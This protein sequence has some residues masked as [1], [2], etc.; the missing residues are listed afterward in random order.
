MVAAYQAQ[1]F[2]TMLVAAESALRARP[3]YPGALFNLALAQ[4]LSGDATASL[5]TLNYLLELGI[6]FGV[7]DIGEFA[8]LSK[9]EGWQRFTERT[10]ELHEPI[11]DASVFA[12]LDAP[13]FVP[14]GIAFGTDGSLYLGSIRKGLLVRG[15]GTVLSDRDGHWSVFGMRFH[16]DGGLWFAS[17]AVPQLETVGEDAGQTGLFRYNVANGQVDKRAML[18]Q[19]AENQVLGDLVI[20][21]D[22]VIY[23]TD[24]LSGAVYR[25]YV[26][27]NEFEVL[28][29]QGELGSPQGLVLDEGGQNLF[30][31]DYT[32]GLY[33]VSLDDGSVLKVSMHESASD[34]GID[35]LYRH[36]RELIAIQNGIRPHRVVALQ[37]D[38]DGQAVTGVRRL[39]SGHPEFDE[40]TLGVVRGDDFYF[41][42]NS[43]WNRF[44][45]DNNLEEG[46]A[47]PVVLR[48]SLR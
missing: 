32:G 11:G 16:Q 27:A 5:H 22:N 39:A 43:H 4:V 29:E 47:G 40:P 13:Q 41:V 45:R 25:Y 30:V 15:D 26:D 36:G 33:R 34:V 18:P 35:G 31:A 2:S 9:L 3:G 24:S 21:S 6:D 38:S 1:D 23:A 14:E 42:A 12:R 17:A 46:L 7:A 10:A 28:V 48:V 19:Y 8:P 20:A 44:D 37:L